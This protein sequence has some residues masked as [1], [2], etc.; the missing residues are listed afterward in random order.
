MAR[1]CSR[2]REQ[3]IGARVN[4]RCCN[5]H[6]QPLRAVVAAACL[7]K[8]RLPPRGGGGGEA[9]WHRFPGRRQAKGEGVRSLFGG[10]LGCDKARLKQF[11]IR[12]EKEG[13]G[14]N[15]GKG[16][17][18]RNSVVCDPLNLPKGFQRFE[19]LR[20]FC[21]GVSTDLG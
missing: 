4:K 1:R 7:S 15:K 17:C 6:P 5:V 21:A 11:R 12:L 9:R 14:V 3:Y 19:I 20:N 18:M 10:D 2:R 13:G 8:Q 16:E